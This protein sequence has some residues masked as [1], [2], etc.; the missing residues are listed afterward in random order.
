MDLDSVSQPAS[1]QHK[2]VGEIIQ[3]AGITEHFVSLPH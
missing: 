3:G 1:L 2:Q